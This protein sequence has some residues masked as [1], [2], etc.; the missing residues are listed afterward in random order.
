M[1]SGRIAIEKAGQ[2]AEIDAEAFIGE[3]AFNGPYWESEAELASYDLTYGERIGWKW[4]QVLRV[5]L[6]GAFLCMQAVGR[7]LIAR[8]KVS[9]PSSGNV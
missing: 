2:Q 1:L 5:H 4:D 8:H 9:A 3:V 7:R 6:T